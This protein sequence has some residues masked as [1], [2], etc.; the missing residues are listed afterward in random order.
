[1]LLSLIDDVPCQAADSTQWYPTRQVMIAFYDGEPSE[2]QEQIADQ[3]IE[4][5]ENID[6]VVSAKSR[7]EHI[8]RG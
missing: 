7:F 4:L 6:E 8:A 1:L 5:M 2:K 3:L